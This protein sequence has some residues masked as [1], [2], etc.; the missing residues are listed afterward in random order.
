MKT[1]AERAAWNFM[2]ECRLR[3]RLVFV[4]PGFA[5]GPLLDGASSTS[6]DVIKLILQGKYPAVPPSAY[7]VVD[8]RDLADLHVA[9]MTAPV[10][11]RRLIAAGE[12]RTMRDMALVL[13]EAH[14]DRARKI[15]TRELPGLV[16]KGMSLFDRSLK[17]VVPDI[18]T[19]PVA[20]AAYVTELTG[21]GFRPAD[22]AVRA[23][24]QSLI[25]QEL[26]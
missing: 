1:R 14:P 19:R 4:N 17:S 9:A 15:P 25:A 6:L 16:V 3:E 11:G 8:V 2:T 18:G 22:D 23:A 10:G 7:P 24:A 12:T 21:V 5:L 26:V 13:R 20:D